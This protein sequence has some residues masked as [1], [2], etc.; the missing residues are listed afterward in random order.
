VAA[1]FAS[2]LN[3]CTEIALM[4]LDVLDHFDPVRVCV[5]Y[6][7]RGE[8]LTT[9]PP[10]PVLERVRPVYEELPGWKSSTHGATRY[11]DVRP[12]YRNRVARVAGFPVVYRQSG[13]RG[14]HTRLVTVLPPEAAT[15][16]LRHLPRARRH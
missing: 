4:K 10:T 1:R 6:E 15:P 9:V 3:G 7:Y 12:G 2:R 14:E 16:Y 8:R 11:G 13:P 5:A